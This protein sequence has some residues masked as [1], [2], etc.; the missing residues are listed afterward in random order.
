MFCSN[1]LFLFEM[2]FLENEFCPS[3]YVWWLKI[4]KLLK[5]YTLDNKQQ[6]SQRY[7]SLWKFH[8]KWA[9]SL[10]T[11]Q[12]FIRM[13]LL[14]EKKT[15][16]RMCVLH[17]F[18]WTKKKSTHFNDW[19]YK[20]EACKQV[21]TPRII[22]NSSEKERTKKERETG[23]IRQKPSKWKLILEKPTKQRPTTRKRFLF[24]VSCKNALFYLN[25]YMR[26]RIYIECVSKR[27]WNE[28]KCT[29]RRWKTWA[30]SHAQRIVK[31]I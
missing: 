10:N 1:I 2:M 24:R 8:E 29:Y 28:M 14:H 5:R 31:W 3:H 30:H 7:C 17:L 27:K 23:H 16:V 18:L 6:A 12:R 25:K 19:M 20:S 13:F 26:L 11:I 15:H 22:V 21:N 9:I 4:L